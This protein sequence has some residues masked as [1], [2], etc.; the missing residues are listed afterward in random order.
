MTAGYAMWP[1]SGWRE[2]K[3]L[4]PED[5]PNLLLDHLDRV[6]SQ[7][8][9]YTVQVPV[10]PE[11]VTDEP[12]M[13]YVRNTLAGAVAEL[14]EPDQRTAITTTGVQWWIRPV[15]SD[16]EEFPVPESRL[17]E[18]RDQPMVMVF[19]RVS[20]ISVPAYIGGTW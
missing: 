13:K 4:T 14:L 19:A 1:A 15:G 17:G 9:P 2:T 10:S 6:W 11:F 16:E 18:F 20:G 8:K 3:L 5:L 12:A 7:R